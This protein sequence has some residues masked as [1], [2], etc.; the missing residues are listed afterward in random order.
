M[1]VHLCTMKVALRAL[2]QFQAAKDA[3][4]GVLHDYLS[5]RLRAANELE[6]Y[7]ESGVADLH[8]RGIGDGQSHITGL[9][10]YHDTDSVAGALDM[11]Q[12][13]VGALNAVAGFD[14]WVARRLAVGNANHL[15][16]RAAVGAGG[17]LNGK[18]R[19]GLVDQLF[20][21]IAFGVSAACS[22]AWTAAARA[23]AR[24]APSPTRSMSV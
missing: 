9:S 1:S 23:S 19:I 6:G 15:E 17:Q 11:A 2:L 10:G 24:W 4:R 8:A 21:V 18:I 12:G 7:A 20:G 22:R 3:G 14:E 13:G 5:R 16:I